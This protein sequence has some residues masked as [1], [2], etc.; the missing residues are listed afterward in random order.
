MDGNN[1]KT[2]STVSTSS[3]QL[4]PLD[5]VSSAPCP[6]AA[7][8]RRRSLYPLQQGSSASAVSSN[9]GGNTFNIHSATT[10]N[11]IGSSNV[12]S[13]N[14]V[15]SIGYTS[16]RGR[17][18]VHHS[19]SKRTGSALRESMLAAGQRNRSFFNISR[20][21][22]SSSI[23][24]NGN[25]IDNGNGSSDSLTQSVN[26]SIKPEACVGERVSSGDRFG[27]VVGS[28]DANSWL[29]VIFDGDS[30]PRRV[31]LKKLTFVRQDPGWYV[32]SHNAQPQR[33]NGRQGNNVQSN[34]STSAAVAGTKSV[35]TEDSDGEDAQVWAQ[36]CVVWLRAAAVGN[37]LC[38]WPARVQKS[39]P[40]QGGLRLHLQKLVWKETISTTYASS[41]SD[42]MSPV[43]G[44]SKNTAEKADATVYDYH[45]ES[46]EDEEEDEDDEEANV[47]E[48]VG[49]QEDGA[50]EKLSDE[51]VR[52]TIEHGGVTYHEGNYVQV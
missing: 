23:S 2:G 15:S 46:K 3:D 11:T 41:R 51:D 30:E 42:K 4:L 22:S 36:G 49:E 17:S 44:I 40:C 37:V 20:S 8:M 24:N 39:E 14:T 48:E 13:S 26:S 38:W 29:S 35:S 10:M 16:S 1:D 52:P 25:E 50:S 28:R 5:I 34:E 12:S 6:A 19:S 47:E 9:G 27:S 31:R 33:E 18:K 45:G 32:V 21:G 43:K 7:A